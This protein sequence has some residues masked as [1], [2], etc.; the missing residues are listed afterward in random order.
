M[1]KTKRGVVI[2]LLGITALASTFAASSTEETTGALGK[3]AH[4]KGNHDSKQTMTDVQKLT[5]KTKIATDLAIVL[6]VST[7]SVL[8]QLNAGKTSADVITTSGQDMI[9]VEAKL[10]AL[11]TAEMKVKLV[12]EVSSGKITQAQADMRLANMVNHTGH[13]DKKKGEMRHAKKDDIQRLT[14]MASVLNTTVSALQAQLSTGKTLEDI[15]KASG[16]SQADFEAKM[17]ILHLA[18]MKIKL[19]AKVS[20]GK[21]TQ[22]EADAKLAK[23]ASHI[24]KTEEKEMREDNPSVGN[25][26]DATTT[27][28]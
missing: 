23:M 2:A 18:E 9:T 20:A 17:K 28:G 7:D 19:Q 24:N 13:T 5:M 3:V 21:I 22:A 10:T 14:A 26:I 16:M 12:T 11:H 4:K 25:K 15:V 27:R 6:G 8:A 1:K